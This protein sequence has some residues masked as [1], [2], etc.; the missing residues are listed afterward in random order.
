VGTERLTLQF[1]NGIELWKP[2]LAVL[3]RKAQEDTHVAV[4]TGL[5]RRSVAASKLAMPQH[6]R[7]CIWVS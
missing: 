3:V 1:K 5:A 4:L 6:T 2:K 7:Q